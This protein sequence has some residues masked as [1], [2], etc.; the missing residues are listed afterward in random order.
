[1]IKYSEAN[2]II[3]KELLK[4]KLTTEEADL[5]DSTN[6]ILAEDI[7]PDINLPPFTNSAMD[8]YAVHYNPDIKKWKIIGEISAGNY[9]DYEL[10]NGLAVSIMTGGKLP[11]EAD[12]SIERGYVGEKL[13]LLGIISS[14]MLKL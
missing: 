12:S 3:E 6:R 4:L 9:R 5:R 8:G 14:I 7:Y 10:G 1:M 11:E 13:I 2:S